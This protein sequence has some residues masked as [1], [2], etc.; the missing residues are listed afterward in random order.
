M[1][2]ISNLRLQRGQKVLLENANARIDVGQRVGIIGRNGTG[3]SSLFA[4]LRGEL[5]ADAG[6]VI[7]P[8]H[9][10]LAHVAQEMP[11]TD[12]SALD[13]VLA[14]DGEL[15]VKR[16][17]NWRE[18]NGAMFGW[19]KSRSRPSATSSGQ[20]CPAGSGEPP[21]STFAVASC[22]LSMQVMRR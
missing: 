1:I 9:W 8:A 13:Y 16:W 15:V 14:G 11:E 21:T 20:V 12:E 3:K 5:H 6:D 19:A 7:I 2:T 17:I 4:L 18:M 22:A 10:V